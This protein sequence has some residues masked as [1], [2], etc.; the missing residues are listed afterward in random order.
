MKA[1]NREAHA[2]LSNI[3]LAEMKQ[4]KK[5]DKE[6]FKKVPDHDDATKQDEFLVSYPLST[7]CPFSRPTQDMLVFDPARKL[8]HNRDYGMPD[9]DNV[10]K[11][12]KLHKVSHTVPFE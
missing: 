4:A 6:S 2:I 10:E 3:R 11:E 8:V 12:G 5:G 7:P 1:M 9:V